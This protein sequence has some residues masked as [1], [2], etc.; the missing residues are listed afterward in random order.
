MNFT[1]VCIGKMRFKPYRDA[2]DE[3]IKRLQ[4]YV[5]TQEIEL[6]PQ[7]A[8]KWSEA[9]VK[10][11]ESEL[12]L[13]SI[14]PQSYLFVM[15]E[16]GKLMDSQTFAQKI[17]SVLVTNPQIAFA[18]GGAYGHDEM[19]RKKAQCVFGLS[20]LTFPHELARVILTEQLYRAMTILKGEPYHK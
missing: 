15:D 7:S 20:P 19:L 1:I 18:I 9:Q 13:Q 16:R 5:P 2:A 8:P 3:Y 12:I 4:H 11:K 17:Q 10:Q 6:K 14:P